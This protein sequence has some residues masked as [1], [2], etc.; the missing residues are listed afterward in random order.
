MHHVYIIHIKSDIVSFCCIQKT[1]KWSIWLVQFFWL[2]FSQSE[3]LAGQALVLGEIS[4]LILL[5]SIWTSDLCSQLTLKTSIFI[6]DSPG[7]KHSRLANKS[8]IISYSFA[9]FCR[10]SLSNALIYVCGKS[11]P[12]TYQIL[13]GHPIKPQ[14]RGLIN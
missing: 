4:Y 13:N 10:V 11:I 12:S 7:N 5:S 1:V 9:T 6:E 14:Y 8:L 2:N 3:E